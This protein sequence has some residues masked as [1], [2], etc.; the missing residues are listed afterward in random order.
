M[1]R[2][3]LRRIPVLLAV[4][5]GLLAVVLPSGKS[6]AADNSLS[7]EQ[8]YVCLPQVRI[9]VNGT[10]NYGE[11]DPEQI[12]VYRGEEK[13]TLTGIQKYAEL[14]EGMVYYVLLDISGSIWDAY[15]ADIKAALQTFY[16]ELSEKDRMALITFGESVTVQLTGEENA[17]EAS[18]KIAALQNTDDQTL[19][20]EALTQAGDMASALS[21]QEYQRKAVIVISDGEDIAKGKS[22]K[23]EALKELKSQGL[24]VY[25]MAVDYEDGQI[26]DSFGEFARNTGGALQI[27]GAGETLN[28]LH[29]IQ[30]RI[31]NS[32]VL[33]LE[34]AD[35]SASQSVETLTVQFHQWNLTKTIEAGFYDWQ[36][37][38]E[39]PQMTEVSQD[40]THKLIVTFSEPV[41]GGEN[42]SNYQL[43]DKEDGT[44]YT[45]V[46]IEEG[47][48]N[49]KILTFEQEFYTGDYSLK[50]VNITDV[51]MEKNQVR[52]EKEISLEGKKKDGKAVIFLRNHGYLIVAAMVLFFLAVFFLIY[53]K[54]RKNQGVVV[55][56]DKMT[57]VSN[58]DVRRH[59]AMEQKKRSGVILIFTMHTKGRYPAR[60]EVPL[61]DSLIA[62]R[63]DICDVYF[64][65]EQMSRQHFALEYEEGVISIMDLDTTNGTM[66]NGVRIQSKRKLEKKD[67]ICA[68]TV[69]MT[70]DWRE[71]D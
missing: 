26:V 18:T 28:G 38:E 58:V 68:G 33:M 30:N 31:M 40:G 46:S 57:M 25:A 10:E 24:P 41:S 16:G 15:F 9:Y 61:F 64:D 69:E 35:N 4:I 17:E 14:D 1:G 60:M 22:T 39:A 37:D 21:G 45:P 11:P 6:F 66:V 59:V 13:L 63:S 42:A 20:F 19:L 65:D 56:D 44:I 34:S 55:V 32:D 67:T 43:K 8:V 36:A 2:R 71:S 5:C 62:G 52:E 50:T 23:D 12:E 7:L 27:V 51:S 53:R 48:N 70:I 47:E 3:K 54:I 49:R 29:A